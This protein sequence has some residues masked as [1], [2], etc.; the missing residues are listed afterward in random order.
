MK[1][2]IM[3]VGI[4]LAS[5]SRGVLAEVADSSPNGF[6][7]KLSVTVKAPPDEAYRTLIRIG[8]WWSSSHTF[9]GNSHNLSIEDKPM[10]CFCEK[11]PDGGGVRHL[12]VVYVSPG[13]KLVMTGGLGPLQSIASAGSMT[14]EVT[15]AEGGAKVRLSY[16]VAGY[17]PAG[18][19]TWAAPV[20]TVLAEQLT[21]FKNYV[22]QGDPAPKP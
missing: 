10:G 22:E 14:I 1:H 7:V 4:L 3:L 21:R 8:D 16:T 12:E 18:M 15:A 2:K 9:S 11:L 13:K 17:Q 19:T 20:D 5:A 6:T